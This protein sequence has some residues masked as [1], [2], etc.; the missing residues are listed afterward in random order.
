VSERTLDLYFGALCEP[1]SVQLER[2]GLTADAKDIK[3]W[4]IDADALSRLYIRGLVRS[5]DRSRIQRA[6]Y[7]KIKRGVKVEEPQS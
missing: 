3:H 1:L 2:Q 7:E 4:Q 5:S 6:L